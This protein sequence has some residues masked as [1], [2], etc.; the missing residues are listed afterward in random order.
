MRRSLAKFGESEASN[1]TPSLADFTTTTPELK[2]SVHTGPGG[3]AS[4]ILTDQDDAEMLASQS[5]T[6]TAVRG[7][8]SACSLLELGGGEIAL[9]RDLS[10]Y[11][12]PQAQ[13]LPRGLS[14]GRRS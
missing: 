8:P 9:G 5:V 11:R 3:F 14:I 4:R 1:H 2:F 7:R 12:L 6:V 13:P 10:R